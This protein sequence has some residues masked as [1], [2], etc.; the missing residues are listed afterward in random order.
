MLLK[1]KIF[2]DLGR[3][4]SALLSSPLLS[5]P[6]FLSFTNSSLTLAL[7]FLGYSYEAGVNPSPAQVWTIL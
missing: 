7:F 2:L 4:K 5:S 3:K 6:P 1:K